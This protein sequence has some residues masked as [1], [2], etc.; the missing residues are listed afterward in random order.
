MSDRKGFIEERCDVGT[1]YTVVFSHLWAEYKKW[2][3]ENEVIPFGRTKFCDGLATLGFFSKAGARNV[4]MRVGLRL[5][6]EF[7]P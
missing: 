2:C 3:A 4:A 6:P 5:K 1:Q 7:A